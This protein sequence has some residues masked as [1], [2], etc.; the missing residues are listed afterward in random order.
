MARSLSTLES[1]LNLEMTN[2]LERLEASGKVLSLV[3]DI[4]H[5]LN[6]SDISL[7]MDDDSSVQAHM[8]PCA[9]CQEHAEW[10]KEKV[11]LQ[12]SQ[13]DLV[14]QLSSLKGEFEKLIQEKK[15]LAK[16]KSKDEENQQVEKVLQPILEQIVDETEGLLLQDLKMRWF[17]ISLC[18]DDEIE[19]Q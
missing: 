17:K 3:E 7:D 2:Q 12:L 15:A 8:P 14:V 10:Q 5:D 1:D 13:K 9:N 4:D 18:T 11:G 6:T 16:Q 19:E